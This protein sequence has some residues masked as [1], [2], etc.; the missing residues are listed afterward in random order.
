MIDEPT[1]SQPQQTD[2]RVTGL[3]M[4]AAMAA[5]MWIV[6]IY[7]A[8]DHYSL[9]KYGIEPREVDGLDGVAFSPF[10]HGSWGHLIG[11][12]VPFLV[13]GGMIALSGLR[14]L[15]VVTLIV[16]AVGGLGVWLF[17]PENTLHIGASGVVFGY[18]GY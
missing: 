11:N 3:L 15:A 9:T 17:A 5:G 7:D 6:Q 13:L 18:A 12:T 2:P 1:T 16:M 4:G 14:R 10:L 8:I